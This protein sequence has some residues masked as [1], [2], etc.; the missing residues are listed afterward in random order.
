VHGS[1]IEIRFIAGKS[2]KLNRSG[3]TLDHLRG[4]NRRAFGHVGNLRNSIKIRFS[5]KIRNFFLRK[6]A[7]V[8][9]PKFYP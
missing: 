6:W 7:K 9:L 8:Q 1:E 2:R 3:C 5:P 4:G